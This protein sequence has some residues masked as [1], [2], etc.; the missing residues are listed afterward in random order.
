MTMCRRIGV[1]AFGCALVLSAADVFAQ[2]SR[3]HVVLKAGVTS[4]HSEDNLA[5]TVA[6][7]GITGAYAFGQR[8]SGE[9]EFWLLQY[10]KDAN[11]DPKHR[12]TLLTFSAIRK[13]Q[14]HRTR[15]FVLAGFSFAQVQ[16]WFTF[17]MADRVRQPSGDTVR[18]SVG[19]DEP[20]VDER[21]RERND[22]RDGYITVGAGLEIPITARAHIVADVRVALA[23]ASVLLRPGIGLAIGL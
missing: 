8:W 12:D 14:A 22:G 16:D 18:A 9:V 23:P 13:L 4:E 5:G 17:C 7:P 2:D 3:G 19:C 11:G 21:R 20:G 10:L 1:A 15:P 6:A